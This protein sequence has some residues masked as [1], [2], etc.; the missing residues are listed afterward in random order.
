MADRVIVWKCRACG[1]V[2][3]YLFLTK[4]GLRAYYEKHIKCDECGGDDLD[5]KVYDKEC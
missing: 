4:A 5:V 2:G 1:E 3:H